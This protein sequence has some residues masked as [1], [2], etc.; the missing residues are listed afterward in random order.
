MALTYLDTSALAKWYLRSLDAMHLSIGR[1]I[2]A[3]V[4]VTADRVMVASVVCV[5]RTLALVVLIV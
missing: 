5:L 2:G 3:R 1:D 4:I